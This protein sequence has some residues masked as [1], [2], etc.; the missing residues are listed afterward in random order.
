MTILRGFII[1][2][3]TNGRSLLWLCD[4]GATEV[5]SKDGMTDMQFSIGDLVLAG[6]DGAVICGPV[7]QAGAAALA[8]SVLDGDPRTLTHPN[9]VLVLASALAGFLTSGDGGETVHAAAIAA[10]QTENMKGHG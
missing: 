4:G 7:G 9:T 2:T 8:R 10:T 3:F 5:M 1:E 6:K